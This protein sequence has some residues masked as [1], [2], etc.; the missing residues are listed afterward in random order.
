MP[1]SKNTTQLG[2]EANTLATSFEYMSYEGNLYAPVDYETL[3]D[4]VIPPMERKC[5]IPVSST[6]IRNKALI[7]FD[8]LFKEGRQLTNFVFMVEQLATPARNVKPWLMIKTSEG[9]RVLH[10]DG[11]LHEPTGEFVPNML[12]PVLNTDADDKAE[13]LKV[14]THWVGDEEE[15]ARSLLRHLATALAPHWSAGK[16]VLLIGDG[17]NG[18][19]VLLTMLKDLFGRHNCS[20]VE[21]QLISAGSS[22][23]FDLNGKLLNLVFDG[24]AEFVKDSGKEKTII[25]GEPISVRKLYANEM[26]TI[27]TNALFVEGL[28]QEPRSK[29]KSSALQAR[30]VRFWFPNKYAEDD[31]FFLRM[32]SEQMLGALLSLLLDHYVMPETKAFM[33]APTTLSR[34]LQLEHMEDNSLALQFLLYVEETDPLGAEAVL[35]GESFDTLVQLFQSWRLKSNDLTVWDKSTL[36]NMFRPVLSTVRKSKRPNGRANPIKILVIGGFKPD[37][38]ELLEALKEEE[39]DAITVVDE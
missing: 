24:P 10:E 25:T 14:I 9:L 20:N 26:S 33:L 11:T 32:R 31:M 35:V 39:A 6:D 15:E 17:R 23:A 19:S 38:L 18:K 29:D 3:D 16:Y 12:V 7:Q 36:I 37:T 5:W 30:L 8:T 34:R 22:G 1:A 4:S 2:D 27:Q 13:L 28:N 21:R